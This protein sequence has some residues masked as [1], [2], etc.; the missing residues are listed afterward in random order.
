[1]AITHVKGDFDE[2]HFPKDFGFSGS[3]EKGPKGRTGAKDR[4]DPAAAT[5]K[6]VTAEND[7]PA[8]ESEGGGSN[9]A[10][11]GNI[12]PDGHDPHGTHHRPDGMI[13]IMHTHG[14]HTLHHPD[15]HV[16]HH[17]AEGNE[18][19]AHGGEH[20]NPGYAHGSAVHTHPH[21]HAMIGHPESMP[22]GSEIH[23]HAHGGMTVHHADGRITHH[24]EHGSMVT[25]AEKAMMK[26]AVSQHEDQEHEGDHAEIHLAR[27]GAPGMRPRIPKAMRPK[28]ETMHSP[29]NTPPKNPM[30]N[31]SPRN[32]APGGALG[33]GVEPS[34]EPDTAGADQSGMGDQGVPQFSRGGRRDR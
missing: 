20:M 23:H 17:D 21:G 32:A 5:T 31:V 22:D 6:P 16:S 7:H 10:K 12:H 28:S 2:S 34:A 33:Y 13:I 27:G 11:G 25:H 14:G 18:M 24:D 3:T 4:N 30:R 26:R 1:M 29:I 9:F 19:H 8:E 15:G